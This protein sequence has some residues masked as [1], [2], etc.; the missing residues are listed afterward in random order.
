MPDRRTFLKQT[1]AG[2]LALPWVQRIAGAEAQPAPAA[3]R[4]FSISNQLRLSVRDFG[5]AGDGEKK[6]TAAFQTA[7]DRCGVLGGGVVVVP[8]GRYLIGSTQLRSHVTLRLEKDA[9]LAGSPE[10]DDYPLTQIRWEGKWVE[11]HIG[12]LY[13]M[14]AQNIAIV[15]EG[16]IEGFTPAHVQPNSEIKQRRPV[17]I[18]PIRCSGIL[19]E[20]FSTHYHGIWSIHPTA[21]EDLIAR[22]LTIRSEGGNGDGIDVDS[23][24]RVRIEHCDIATG[25]DCISLK[26]GRGSEGFL[27]AQPTEDVTISDCTFADSL[28]A[29]IGIGSEA[30]GG[31]RRVRIERCRFSGAKSNAIYIKTHVGRGGTIEEITA[32]DLRISGVEGAAF[33]FNLVS[34]GKQ[35]EN[36]VPGAEG[37]PTVRNIR[38]ARIHVDGAPQLVEAVNCHPGK[39]LDGFS[40]THVSGS[41]ARGIYLAN[42]RNVEIADVRLNGL[43]TPLLNLANV[44]GKGLDNAA[45]IDAPSVE[46][47]IAA[48]AESYHLR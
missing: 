18:E 38:Y 10:E 27:L 14:D 37:I 47:A 44:T 16:R 9:V 4:S 34:S 36:P 35:D 20:G 2:L 29:C 26:S 33:R 25:D 43:T 15:G 32:E 3:A 31:I 45:R 13:A 17:L 23:C 22:N 1:S 21:C 30:S 5:A 39:P 7:L 28:F 8:A 11:G 42:M 12:L 46:S 24:R 19:L 40:L 41:A 48:P 6:D